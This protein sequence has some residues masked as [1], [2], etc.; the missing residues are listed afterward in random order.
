MAN[1]NGTIP[2]FAPRAGGG[3]GGGGGSALIWEELANAPIKDWQ[4]NQAVY[5][6]AAG[7][8]QELYTT[9]KVPDSYTAGNPIKI[10]LL[11]YSADTSGNVLIRAQSTLIR[12]GT[13]EVTSTTNQRTTTNSA[14][15]M[16]GSNDMIPQAVELDIS[17]S[18][19]QVNSVSIAAGDTLIIRLYRDTD[20]ATGDLIFIENSGEP[21]FQ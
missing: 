5:L 7:L 17:S 20:T 21:T 13:D 9:L 2:L 14:I 10:L 16:S 6:F 3:A 12:T 19:G 8:A 15:T 1:A 4:N 11:V 18:S